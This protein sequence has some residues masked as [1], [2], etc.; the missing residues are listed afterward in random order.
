MW[1][2]LLA[3]LPRRPRFVSRPVRRRL[4]SRLVLLVVGRGVVVLVVP[5]SVA[6][7]SLPSVVLVSPVRLVLLVVGRNEC[8]GSCRG[9]V[10]RAGAGRCRSCSSCGGGV[11]GSECRLVPRPVFACRGTGR[12]LCWCCGL[13]ILYI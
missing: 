12:R 7:S 8:R 1:I 9:I 6:P 2:R 10:H 13:P 5:C 11:A 3:P 4:V